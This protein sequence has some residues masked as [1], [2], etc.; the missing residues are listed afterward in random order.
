MVLDATKVINGTFGEVWNDGKWLTNVHPPKVLLK[1][2]RKKF[3]VP[4]HVG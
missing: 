2:T 4:G 3:R 1:L